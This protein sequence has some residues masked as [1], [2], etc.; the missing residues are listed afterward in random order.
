MSVDITEKSNLIRLWIT[1][2]YDY[3]ERY[4][5]IEEDGDDINFEITG[6]N[7]IPFNTY[8]NSIQASKSSHYDYFEIVKIIIYG[9][10]LNTSKI[11]KIVWTLKDIN[12][13][14]YT[15][16]A[17]Q[18]N[19]FNPLKGKMITDFKID[20]DNSKKIFN[21]LKDAGTSLSKSRTSEAFKKIDYKDLIKK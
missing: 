19:Y 17:D 18:D 5:T 8:T 11:I 1:D 9:K 20:N 10:D 3:N 4:I 21:F 6:M 12:V 16:V 7:M 15:Q 2:L 13:T 14:K